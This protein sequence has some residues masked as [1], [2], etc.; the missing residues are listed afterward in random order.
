MFTV[1]RPRTPA[2]RFEGPADPQ[3]LS[4]PTCMTAE[5]CG[6]L[7]RDLVAAQSP[8]IAPRP[9]I[10]PLPAWVGVDFTLPVTTG[11]RARRAPA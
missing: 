5:L 1:I 7:E 11:A 10:A 8:A 4:F 6:D 9:S 2:G 3:G